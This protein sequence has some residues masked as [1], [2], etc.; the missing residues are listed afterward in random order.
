MRLEI[1]SL[2]LIILTTFSF[3]KKPP[4]DIPEN[5]STLERRQ[6]IEQRLEEE[7]RVVDG[8]GNSLPR[9]V[10]GGGTSPQEVG[11]RETQNQIELGEVGNNPS[12]QRNAYVPLA[13]RRKIEAEK[14]AEWRAA[15]LFIILYAI[16]LNEVFYH[17]AK[18]F[19]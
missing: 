12:P 8:R 9:T 19:L 10:N 7:Q 4:A 11:G 3:S 16:C 18:R 6:Q 1:F 17:S 5:T 15:R 2:G 14:R 13:E